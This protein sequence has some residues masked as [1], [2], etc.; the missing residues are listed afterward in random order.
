[1][2]CT[3]RSCVGQAPLGP[4]DRLCP[5][6]QRRP[7]RAADQV[8]SA[9]HRAPSAKQQAPSTNLQATCIK[10]K[11]KTSGTMNRPPRTMAPVPTTGTN[12]EAQTAER[13]LGERDRGP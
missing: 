12:H 10:L 3:G 11:H 1:M 6:R 5:C 13:I 8:P 7:S 9:K 2:W 4:T